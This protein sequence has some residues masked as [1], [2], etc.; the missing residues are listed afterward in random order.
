M[1]SAPPF[2]RAAAVAVDEQS[3]LRTKPRRRRAPLHPRDPAPFGE[4]ENGGRPASP[5][6]R[7]HCGPTPT[8][9]WAPFTPRRPV[10]HGEGSPFQFGVRDVA[11]RKSLTLAASTKPAGTTASASDSGSAPDARRATIAS[12]LE[13]RLFVRRERPRGPRS[14]LAWT[15]RSASGQRWLRRQALPLWIRRTDASAP[16]SSR[17]R[18]VRLR[19]C[20]GPERT[21]D[22]PRADARSWWELG[23]ASPLPSLAGLATRSSRGGGVRPKPPIRPQARRAWPGGLAPGHPASVVVPQARRMD[24]YITRF[25]FRL[26][27]VLTAA[28]LHGA[29]RAPA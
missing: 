10:V 22:T 6:R 21:S 20:T 15:V 26:D 2:A 8:R 4:L 16:D 19:T 23:A 25:L 14:A 17:T 11:A 28:A 1:S 18:T 3:A 5:S 13:S 7:T 9:H 27:G 29:G 12:G 24:S